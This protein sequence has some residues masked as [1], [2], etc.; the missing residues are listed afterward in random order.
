MKRRLHI[1]VSM[2]LLA[3]LLAACAGGGVLQLGNLTFDFGQF[4]PVPTR[5]SSHVSLEFD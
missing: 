3:A 5:V 2:A 1:F 4:G